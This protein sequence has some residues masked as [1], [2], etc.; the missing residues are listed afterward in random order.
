MQT[1]EAV[2]SVGAPLLFDRV[3]VGYGS[4]LVVGG[5]S[6]EVAAGE[7]VGLV[8]PNGAGKSTLL[9]AITGD[10]DLLGGELRVLGRDA[11]TLPV[12]DRARLVGV[13]PQHVTSAFS[14]P[15]R[16]FVALARH[17][18]MPR[19][20]SLSQRD[21]EI[22][23]HA[24][25]RTD[26]LRLAEQPADELSGGDLQRLA[27]AQTLAQEPRV[28]LL[29]EPT[30]HLDLNHRLQVLDLTRELADAG[31]AVL[32]VFHDLDLAARYADRVC[33]VAQGHADPIGPPEEVLTAPML[34]E[35]F[36]VRAV[37]GTDVVTGAVS[38]TPVLREQAVAGEPRGR[39]LVIGGS[40]AA[41][42]LMRR[43]V[44]SGWQVTAGALSAGD[45]DQTVAEA[46][47]LEHVE[48]PPFASMDD[49]A[50]AR[51]RELARAA[52]AIVVTDVPFGHGNVGNLRAVAESGKSVVLIGDIAGRDFT[53]GEATR[54]WETA[55]AA[56]ARVV[57]DGDE[58]EAAL[59]R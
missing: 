9:R 25:E 47:G 39:V 46:L 14:L 13:V 10:A 55:V 27:Y 32:A 1:A 37:V 36:G 34:R 50:E 8:G 31:M 56:D 51:V 42:P 18:H 6:F 28:L 21:A 4:L 57:H 48:L 16:E 12:R 59:T 15:A 22:V 35:V 40:G 43:L 17:S 38:V 53:G 19:F 44:M 24:M 3:D 45:S 52:D 23:E 54:A 49:A 5:V 26:T 2:S 29:D 41:A 11:R 7:V 33:V 30:S 20:A 58:A